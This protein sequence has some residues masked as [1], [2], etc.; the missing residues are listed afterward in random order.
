MSS[1]HRLGNEWQ[2]VV[3]ISTAA[4]S[5]YLFLKPGRGHRKAQYETP[6]MLAAT[7]WKRNSNSHEWTLKRPL[8]RDSGQA[9][10]GRSNPHIS[11]STQPSALPT[12]SMPVNRSR[13]T[14]SLFSKEQGNER[15]QTHRERWERAD[16]SPSPG[17]IIRMLMIDNKDGSCFGF[18]ALVPM[19][20]GMFNSEP[21][22]FV[23]SLSSCHFPLV[24]L[25]P[26]PPPLLIKLVFTKQ[27]FD[28]SNGVMPYRLW[29]VWSRSPVF[30]PLK[31]HVNEYFT[32]N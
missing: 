16:Q 29:N 11:R 15:R 30:L 21:F 14:V 18:Q 32:Y 20:K 9:D 22:A 8:K 10:T 5:C 24:V 6:R 12:S 2:E 17:S 27:C 3:G 7:D 26:Y 23:N 31:C 4:W 25:C 1:I 13:S 19:W 28:K